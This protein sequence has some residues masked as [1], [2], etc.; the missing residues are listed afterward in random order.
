MKQ[1]VIVL[2]FFVFVGNIFCQNIEKYREK[3]Q[4]KT[5]SCLIEYINKLA[6]DSAK[7]NPELSYQLSLKST[8]LSRKINFK[9]GL[10]HSIYNLSYYYMYQYRSKEAIEM[11]KIAIELAKFLKDTLYLAKAYNIAGI[12]VSD[13]GNYNGS[14]EYYIKSLEFANYINNQDVAALAYINSGVSYYYLADYEKSA[15]NYL[16]SL[17]IFEAKKDTEKTI[18]VLNNLASVYSSNK[19][20]KEAIKTVQKAL[21]L[22]LKKNDEIPLADCYNNLFAE[23]YRLDSLDKALYYLDKATKIYFKKNDI[24]NLAIAYNNYSSISSKKQQ[25]DKALEYAKKALYFIRQTDMNSEEAF[26][27]HTLANTYS[28]MKNYEMAIKYANESLSKAKNNNNNDVILKCKELLAQLYFKKQQYKQAAESYADYQVLKDSLYKEEFENNI[29]EMSTKYEVEKKEKEL[30]QKNL[31]IEKQEK[32]NKIQRLLR[33]M[34]LIGLISIFVVSLLILRSY[35][36]KKKANAIILD[37]NHQLEHANEEITAQKREIES[38]R[39]LVLQQKQHIELI[40]KD[41]T[42]SINYAE[43]IQRSFLATKNTL[44]KSLNN[45]FILFKPKDIVSG[46]F[47]WA[48]K[49]LN[50]NFVFVTAD[51]TGHGVPGAIMSILIIKTLE[52]AIEKGYI[53]P[54]DILNYTRKQIIDRLKNDGSEE[55]GKDGMDANILSYN[56]NSRKI[57]YS[58]AHNPIWVYRNG[59]IVELE[60]D[61]MPV[62]KHEKDNILFNQYE[63]EL[64]KSDIIYTFTD[65]FADQFGGPKNKKFTYKRLKDT[66]IQNATKPL[67]DQ[68]NIFEET[69]LTWKQDEEQIDDLTFIGINF[70]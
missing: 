40:H 30:I 54:S 11:A 34:L 48:A 22:A 60:F 23:Y 47:Y 36:L 25:Y 38:Q 65:G 31:E 8:A 3:L 43:R 62:G 49:D 59:E 24:R 20:S 32:N 51:C 1:I 6:S 14:L 39:D 26:Y 13:T 5:D 56:T 37:K 42:D 35:R 52:Q 70:F 45:Y 61:R 16:K 46:D 66:I 57:I 67:N 29:A 15:D 68:K 33:N 10:L 18:Q 55:G 50:G 9:K 58:A 41:L 44:T 64:Q 19:S 12:S 28:Q 21:K 17:R 27:L 53:H 7:A 69:F 4:C 2:L 63:F